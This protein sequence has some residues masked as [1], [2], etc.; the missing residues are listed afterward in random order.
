L[1][2]LENLVIGRALAERYRIDE[3]IGRGGMGA[4]Y[5]AVDECLG[6]P[7]AVKVINVAVSDPEQATELCMRFQHEDRVAA[8]LRHPTVIRVYD[9]GT[10]PKLGLDFLVMELLHGQDLAT[11]IAHSGPPLLCPHRTA[12]CA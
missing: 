1:A 3:M 8:S 4:V 11:C 9:F 6:R 2:G 7:V 5:R 10:G 12:S